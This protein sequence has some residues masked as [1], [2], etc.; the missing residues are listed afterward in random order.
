MAKD[1]KTEK[2][3]PKRRNEAKKKG[4]LP[5]SS[6]FNGAVVLVVGIVALIALGGSIVAGAAG[7]MQQVFGMIATPGAATSASGLSVLEHMVM[8]T[9]MH[10]VA[11]IAGVCLG[12]AMVVNI[13]QV[14]VRPS[15]GRIKPDVKRVNPLSGLKNLFGPRI[16]FESGKALTKVIA[17]GAVTAIA[18][19]PQ[20]THL[21]A[22]VGT[23]PATLLHQLASGSVGIA[24]RAAIAY[25]LI[26]L[27][28][29]VY[30]RRKF[31]KDLKMT[32]QEVKDEAKQY[33]L[34]PE[35]RGAIRRRQMMASRQRMMAAVPQA[36]VIVT[37]PT[38]YAVALSYDGKSAAPI[39][40]AKGKNHIAAQI[41]RIAQENNVPIVP[42]PPL[43]RALHASVELGQ[44]I[45]E[46]FYA[47]VA[48]VLAFVYR[49]AARRKAGAL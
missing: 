42:D 35:V 30:Q 18:L 37:N 28:D 40:V 23:S 4:Q 19:V 46:D 20:I 41:R 29:L 1:D 22:N 13:A 16:L 43:A 10:T 31:E 34:P 25:V 17:V 48:Q 32:K 9:L 2:A 12:A 44:M 27:I 7:A 6:D 21:A 8:N 5:K 47:A 24:E 26:G 3:T 38:H 39:V 15:F 14:G 11:P 49:L 33:Q 45:S 36:D